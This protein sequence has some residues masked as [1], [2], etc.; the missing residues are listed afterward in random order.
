MKLVRY[1]HVN[2]NGECRVTRNP[3]GTWHEVTFRL[4]L[5]IPDVWGRVIGN[6]DI[7]LPAPT[8]ASIRVMIEQAKKEADAMGKQQPEARTSPKARR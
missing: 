6:V 7:T 2:A 8:P 1:L 3:G 5:E 4:N